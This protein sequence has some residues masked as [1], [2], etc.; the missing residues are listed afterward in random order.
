[1]DTPNRKENIAKLLGFLKQ[2]GYASKGLSLEGLDTRLQNDSLRRNLYNALSRD[3]VPDIGSWDEFSSMVKKEKDSTA[4]AQPS[5]KATS[6]PLVPNSPLLPSP[7]KTS[8][9]TLSTDWTKPTPQFS[10]PTS[11]RNPGVPTLVPSREHPYVGR[12][13]AFV[14][15]AEV[16][17]QR[18]GKKHYDASKTSV[19]YPNEIGE[20]NTRKAIDNYTQAKASE[21]NR[22]DRKIEAQLQDIEKQQKELEARLNKRAKELEAE[23]EGEGWFANFI[24]SQPA[25]GMD[26]MSTINRLTNDGKDQDEEYIGLSSALHNLRKQKEKLLATKKSMQEDASFGP[27]LKNV[28]QGFLD[29][30]TDTRIWDGGEGDL[31]EA[32]LAIKAI[33]KL[34]LQ[35]KFNS[36]QATKEDAELLRTLYKG[37]LKLTPAEDALL[38]SKAG[39]AY[40]DAI[41]KEAIGYGYGAG[42]TTANMLPFIRDIAL[43]PVNGLGRTVATNV[44]KSALKSGLSR[45]AT[46]AISRTARVVGDIALEGAGTALTTG[47]G[48]TLK[49]TADEQI[50]DIKYDVDSKTGQIVYG[51]RT[52]QEENFLKAFGKSLV[53]QALEYGTEATGGAYIGT[54]MK[55][56]NKYGGKLLT[57]TLGDKAVSA[58]EKFF[59]RMEKT[60]VGKAVNSVGEQ[61]HYDGLPGEYLEE[62]YNNLL[63]AI[64]IGDMKLDTNSNNGVFNPEIN[65]TIIIGL[66]G[67]PMATVSLKVGSIVAQD[68]KTQAMGL[69]AFGYKQWQEMKT[70]IGN[71]DDVSKTI[72]EWAEQNPNATSNQKKAIMRYAVATAMEDAM[73][74][75]QAL[76]QKERKKDLL[77]P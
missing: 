26:P 58:V 33:G 59:A 7:N 74:V 6:T 49:G 19:I 72:S 76:E 24:R 44:A 1:M 42:E 53:R 68:T 71:S 55:P 22:L 23:R 13:L 14:S 37:Q 69:R 41:T 5:T 21:A 63:N 12:E 57:K 52:N 18:T 4:L 11:E 16:T 35:K 50:G 67:A 10:I 17:N 2:N 27:F 75:R 3:K 48:G 30:V 32:G 65:K 39:R 77:P 36:G 40:V 60:S 25:R 70:L 43:S 29:T 54:L 46:K 73:T 62:V 64:T 34:E 51:G 56:I 61:V 45:V 9:N 8:K 38:N 66:M 31:R 20:D 28:G 47:M 15:P